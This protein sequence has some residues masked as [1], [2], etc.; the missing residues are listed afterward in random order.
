MNDIDRQTRRSMSFEWRDALDLFRL[1]L[2]TKQLPDSTPEQGLEPRIEAADDK[3][4]AAVLVGRLEYQ[5]RWYARK[6]G[7]SVL[8]FL[9]FQTALVLISV[10]NGIYPW[11]ARCQFVVVALTT[12]A[13]LGLI[14]LRDFLDSGPLTFQYVQAAGRLAR[15]RD[16]F[17]KGEGELAGGTDIE[18][19]RRLVEAIEQAHTSDFQHWYAS[20]R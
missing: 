13:S 19:L 12:A 8:L 20:H 17:E 14:S 10:F 5:R 2:D 16:S 18:K 11:L 4:R 9:A 15:I 3:A 7:G 1:W 6:A